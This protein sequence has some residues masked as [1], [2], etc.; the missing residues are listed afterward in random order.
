MHEDDKIMR[1]IRTSIVVF[2][3]VFALVFA[4]AGKAWS[5]NAADNHPSKAEVAAKKARTE[6][7]KA[8]AE[9]QKAMAEA[10]ETIRQ[11]QMKREHARK[12]EKDAFQKMVS[13]GYYPSDI[14][15]TAQNGRVRAVFSHKKHLLRENL[16]CTACHPKIFIM[17]VDNND[18]KH[19]GAF[20]MVSM[21]KGKYCGYCHNGDRAF[22]VEDLAS[23]KLCHPKQL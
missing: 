14:T 15:L 4:P 22:S 16:K 9:A 19:P 12:I 3:V 13:A 6:A 8:L 1:I 21:K 5:A 2:V 20:T 23:C 17:K 18:V 7:A 11:A 10:D